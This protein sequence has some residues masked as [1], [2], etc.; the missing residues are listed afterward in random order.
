MAVAYEDRFVEFNKKYAGKG[1]KFVAINANRRTEDLAAM[2]TRAEE[3]GFNF[4]AQSGIAATGDLTT[5]TL[6]SLVEADAEPSR[7]RLRWFAADAHGLSETVYRRTATEVWKAIGQVTSDG[8]GFL[9]YEDTQVSSGT[10]YGYRLGVLQGG[11]EQ[12]LGEAWIDTPG[13]PRFQLAGQCPNP[14]LH[15]LNVAFSLP[16]ASPAELELFDVAGRRLAS[17]EVGG[18]GAGSHIVSLWSAPIP[19]VYL[20]RLTQRGRSLT[21]RAVIIQ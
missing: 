10:G 1:V 20:L 17:R 2:K 15:G 9:R 12:F 4:P 3:K 21:G 13:G 8:T 6:L 14:T 18:L 5:P 7:V 16:D 19:G 11:S